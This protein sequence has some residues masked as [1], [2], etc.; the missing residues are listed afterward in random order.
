LLANFTLDGIEQAIEKSLD[1]ITKNRE[2]KLT[3]KRRDGTKT[4]I[5]LR[6]IVCRFADDVV[7]IG[8]SKNILEKYIKPALILFLKERGLRLSMEKTTLG[9]I[10]EKELNYLGY[11]FKYQEK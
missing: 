1:R 8:R 11:T 10:K 3:I 5:N 9:S 6:P 2:K 7:I 4:S